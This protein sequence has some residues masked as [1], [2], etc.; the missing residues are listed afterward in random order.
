MPN[1]T[2][3]N[4]AKDTFAL[5]LLQFSFFS[6]VQF[7]VQFWPRKSVSIRF[8]FGFCQHIN[9]KNSYF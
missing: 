1:C 4:N 6:S 3:Y 2:S 7:S 5:M 8:G 9:S